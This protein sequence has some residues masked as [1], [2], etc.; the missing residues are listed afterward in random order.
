MGNTSSK[1]AFYVDFDLLR[2]KVVQEMKVRVT[3]QYQIT[4]DTGINTATLSRFLT[5]N[6]EIQSEGVS[7]DIFVT[8]MRWGNFS[9][10]EMIKRRRGFAARHSDTAEQKELRAITALL[11]EAGVTLEA[12]E[13]VSA[14]LARVIGSS[15]K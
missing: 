10:G 1:S 13:S 5:P 6:K 14:M 15:K 11:E 7:A 2:E 8:L 4:R 9:Y 3:T 12:G